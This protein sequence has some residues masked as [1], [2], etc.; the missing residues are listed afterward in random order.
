MVEGIY[1]ND[2]NGVLG[3]ILKEIELKVLNKVNI[4]E[5]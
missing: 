5:D 3:K 1:G 2:E 4:F